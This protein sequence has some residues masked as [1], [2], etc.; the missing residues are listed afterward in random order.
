VDQAAR[1]HDLWVAVAA[2]GPILV[3][4][5]AVTVN[6]YDFWGPLRSVY[7]PWRTE[8]H[9]LCTEG[10]GW[11]VPYRHI[12]RYE[13]IARRSYVRWAAWSQGV[14]WLGFL[15]AAVAT[16][17]AL[18][19]LARND[20]TWPTWLPIALLVVAGGCIPTQSGIAGIVRVKAR[21][22]EVQPP[23]SSSGG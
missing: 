20:D 9:R 12:T 3:L 6:I 8:D 5:T 14:S 16:L 13:Q 23:F 18:I 21:E 2:A 22:A 11:R 19:S 4:A 1:H 17:Q 15:T 10:E 7:R